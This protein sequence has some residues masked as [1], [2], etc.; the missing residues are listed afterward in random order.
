MMKR[1]VLT[2]ITLTFRDK[3]MDMQDI[4]VTH[5]PMSFSPH[6][7]CYPDALTLH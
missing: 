6:V 3:N 2:S 7:L 5:W 4:R 1:K